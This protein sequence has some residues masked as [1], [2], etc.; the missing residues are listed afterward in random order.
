MGNVSKPLSIDNAARYAECA[1]K[2]K[3]YAAEERDFKLREKMLEIARGYD[4]LR[5]RALERH[6]RKDVL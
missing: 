2:W 1:E 6:N 4:Y 5:L 3:R